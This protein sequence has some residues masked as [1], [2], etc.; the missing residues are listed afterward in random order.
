MTKMRCRLTCVLI[1]AAAMLTS[2][3]T[4]LIGM[5]QAVECFDQLRCADPAEW[6]AAPLVYAV[7]NIWTMAFGDYTAALRVLALLCYAFSIGAGCLWLN[8]HIGKPVFTASLFAVLLVSTRWFAP[9][10]YGPDAG[11][12]PWITLALLATLHFIRRPD[13]RRAALLLGFGAA[14]MVMARTATAVAIPVLLAVIAVKCRHRPVIPLTLF[15]AGFA[16]LA[17]IGRYLLL[18]DAPLA[19]CIGNAFDHVSET[20][21]S[22]YLYGISSATYVIALFFAAYLIRR[23]KSHRLLTISA[24]V[25]LGLIVVIDEIRRMEYSMI[26]FWVWI[27]LPLVF[28]NLCKSFFSK[29]SEKIMPSPAQWVILFFAA[30]PAVGSKLILEHFMAVAAIPFAVAPAWPILTSRPIISTFYKATASVVAFAAMYALGLPVLHTPTPGSTLSAEWKG[31]VATYLDM[32][33]TENITDAIRSLPADIDSTAIIAPRAYIGLKITGHNPGHDN[34]LILSGSFRH[35]RQKIAA[36]ISGKP[37]LY[38]P[39][40][41]YLSRQ[42]IIALKQ[43]IE[44]QGYKQTSPQGHILYTLYTRK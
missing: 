33:A 17:V 11:A 35:D 38:I 10:H 16:P 1:V 18:P 42:D 39:H 29:R 34:H 37:Y 5:P 15:I 2:L 36:L 8:G 28:I 26:C 3:A 44:G 20:T 7:G 13:S 22:F 25:I 41:A 32:R 19:F 23:F 12:F 14:M 9:W 27:L 31:I 30:L 21:A 40:E 6:G 4:W 43:F 24:L